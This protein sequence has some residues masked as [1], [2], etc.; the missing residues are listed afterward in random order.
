MIFRMSTTNQSARQDVRIDLMTSVDWPN[1]ASI[2]LEGIATGNATFETLTPSWEEWDRLHLPFGRLVARQGRTIAGWAAL[3][4]VSQRS[5]Y[6][7]VAELSV[8]V[9]SWGRGKRVGTALM[10]A[11]VEASERNGIWTLQGT[12]FPENVASLKMCQAVGFRELGRRE[13]VGKL[14]GQWRDTVIVERRSKA[15]GLE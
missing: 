15:V 1:V 11:A 4:R 14:L 2:Y 9:A 13:R 12:V 10:Q 3:S 7:G 5:C 6:A 8:Y